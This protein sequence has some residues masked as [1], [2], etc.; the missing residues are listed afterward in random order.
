MILLTYASLVFSGMNVTIDNQ[1]KVKRLALV[2]G[3]SSYQN[4][5]LKNPVNDAKDMAATLRT[6]GFKVIELIEFNA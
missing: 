6:V 4:A 2:I 1:Q 3:N 5:P